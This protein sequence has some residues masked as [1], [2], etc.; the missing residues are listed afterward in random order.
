MATYS[1]RGGDLLDREGWNDFES[2]LEDCIDFEAFHDCNCPGFPNE[3][4][5]NTTRTVR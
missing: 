4:I 5:P 1:S 3:V 2:F